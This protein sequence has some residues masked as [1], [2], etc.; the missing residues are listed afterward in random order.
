MKGKCQ[1]AMCPYNAKYGL[2]H[3]AGDVKAWIRVCPYHERIISHENLMLEHKAKRQSLPL[4]NPLTKI[5][6]E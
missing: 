6:R 1:V 4:R 5:R 3:A 2:Y